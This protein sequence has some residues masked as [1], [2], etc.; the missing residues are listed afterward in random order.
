MAVL[1]G[2]TVAAA[3]LTFKREVP[4]GVV[5]GVNMAFNTSIAYQAGTLMVFLNG[6]ALT[7]TDDF[8]EGGG[9][10]LTLVSAPSNTG[11]YT[12]KLLVTFLV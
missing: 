8:S 6:I 10:L 1:K 2:G 9:T 7:P 11:G 5:D 12:D 3:S 4:S